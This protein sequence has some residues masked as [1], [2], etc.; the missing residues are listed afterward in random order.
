MN[1]YIVYKQKADFL[2]RLVQTPQIFVLH[3]H[4]CTKEKATQLYILD[5]YEL[6]PLTLFT[7]LL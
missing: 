4:V 2:L 3:A 1:V 6:A 5:E 7:H